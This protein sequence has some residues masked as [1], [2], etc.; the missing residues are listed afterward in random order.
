[1]PDLTVQDDWTGGGV[2]MRDIGRRM[3]CAMTV[4]RVGGRELA[5]ALSVTGATVSRW[6]SGRQRIG[7]KAAHQAAEALR[8][9]PGWLISGGPLDTDCDYLIGRLRGE[10]VM[11]SPAKRAAVLIAVMDAVAALGQEVSGA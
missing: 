5:R 4:Q 7:I 11:L 6:Q 3:R 1:M 10:M 2:F 8:V 9:P